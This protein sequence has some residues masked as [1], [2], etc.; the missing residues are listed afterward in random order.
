MNGYYLLDTSDKLEV[1]EISAKSLIMGA[2]LGKLILID[3]KQVEELRMKY[4]I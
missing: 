1:A 2:S 4:L 3:D